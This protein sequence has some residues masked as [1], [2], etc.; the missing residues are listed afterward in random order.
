M[1]EISHLYQEME[2]FISAKR[3]SLEMEAV[4]LALEERF[5]EIDRLGICQS[6]DSAGYAA[7]R[8]TARHAQEMR[9]AG[10]Y[11]A[12]R[13]EVLAQDCRSCHVKMRDFLDNVETVLKM[14]LDKVML[15]SR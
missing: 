14:R 15:D 3:D 6:C 8:A 5:W 7:M 9:L 12:K 11:T 13:F 4:T 1:G 10:E 2:R